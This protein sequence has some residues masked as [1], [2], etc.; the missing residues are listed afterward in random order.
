[1]RSLANLEEAKRAAHGLVLALCVLH[2]LLQCLQ[3]AIADRGS[4]LDTKSRATRTVHLALSQSLVGGLGALGMLLLQLSQSR[5]NLR[6]S[7]G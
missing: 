1:M 6:Y 5:L 7:A 4:V 2:A 3:Q